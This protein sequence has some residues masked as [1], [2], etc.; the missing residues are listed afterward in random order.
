MCSSVKEG[1]TVINNLH[2]ANN[3]VCMMHL[4]LL[5]HLTVLDY[6]N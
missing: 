5:P 3:Q 2:F 1:H 6:W 4:V